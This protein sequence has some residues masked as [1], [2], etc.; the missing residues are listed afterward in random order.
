MSW[1]IFRKKNVQN[2]SN[3][4]SCSGSKMSYHQKWRLE[5]PQRLKSDFFGLLAARNC[6]L[7]AEHLSGHIQQSFQ[8]KIQVKIRCKTVLFDSKK[9]SARTIE[10]VFCCLFSSSAQLLFLQLTLSKNAGLHIFV[11]HIQSK[12]STN[13]KNSNLFSNLPNKHGW[14]T[15]KSTF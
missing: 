15:P 1:V 6:L 7:V 8:V 3:H 13:C 9:H 10:F 14:F 4:Q 5:A 12:K 2:H 11:G